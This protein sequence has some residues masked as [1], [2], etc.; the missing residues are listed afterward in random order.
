MYIQSTSRVVRPHHLIPPTLQHPYHSSSTPP[1][2]TCLPTA[3]SSVSPVCPHHSRYRGA[4]GSRVRAG[5][6]AFG[7]GWSSWERVLHLFQG[8][9]TP[10]I[11]YPR[12]S[13]ASVSVTIVLTY[14]WTGVSL[15]GCRQNFQ[16][17]SPGAVRK[18]INSTLTA[19][20]DTLIDCW[21]IYNNQLLNPNCNKWHFNRL[22]KHIQQS[23]IQP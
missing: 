18:R 20:S 19:I 8:R 12:P 1:D 22:L 21:S 15:K 23:I 7:G 4:A 6:G 9:V 11:L 3:A 2:P 17:R 13:P 10:K 14:K 5:R 16:E